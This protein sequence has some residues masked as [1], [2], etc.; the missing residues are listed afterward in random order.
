M[1]LNQVTVPALDVQA[2]VA[3]Y[4]G[5]GLRLIVSSA[6][7]ARF[8]CPDGGSTFSVHLAEKAAP[9][10]GVV[11]YFECEDLDRRVTD[12][13]ASGYRF[14]REPQDEPWMWREARLLDPAGNE[15]CLYWAGENRRFPPWRVRE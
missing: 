5:L 11:V 2:S 9:S 7:Y 8:E 3:F 10:P 15:V 12:L 1:Q 4:R 14:A 13:K 6:H